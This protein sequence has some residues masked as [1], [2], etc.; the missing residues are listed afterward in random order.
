[1]RVAEMV[2]F[3]KARRFEAVQPIAYEILRAREEW[4]RKNTG[5][6][7]PRNL[8]FQI[9]ALRKKLGCAPIDMSLGALTMKMRRIGVDLKGRKKRIGKT[10]S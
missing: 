2:G 4:C 1:M 7:T 5:N 10:N 6:P 9:N 3:C 8:L